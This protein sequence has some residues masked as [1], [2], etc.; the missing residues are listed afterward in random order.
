MF[1]SWR[2]SEILININL[3]LFSMKGKT[4]ALIAL[5]IALGLGGNRAYKLISQE[6]SHS[7]QATKRHEE[8]IERLERLDNI[9][10][11]E[12]ARHE[13]VLA[14]VKE[15]VVRAYKR[16][17]TLSPN[18]E[19]LQYGQVEERKGGGY[20]FWYRLAKIK[21]WDGRFSRGTDGT[22]ALRTERYTMKLHE[23]AEG[24]EN[25]L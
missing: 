23:A 18:H 19:L 24:L 4:V 14:G 20:R 1:S 22:F 15:A 7:R 25:P 12:S 8:T 16:L 17:K 9:S 2:A 10:L 13:L 11:E 21:E 5:G 6:A 3:F